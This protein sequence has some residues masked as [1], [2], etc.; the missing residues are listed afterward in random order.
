MDTTAEEEYVRQ[1]LDLFVPDLLAR[2]E[3]EPFLRRLF[4]SEK[5]SWLKVRL[6]CEGLSE[7]EG[8]FQSIETRSASELV[9]VWLDHPTQP[10]YSYVHFYH[11]DFFWTNSAIYN[12][13]VLDSE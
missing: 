10:G 13:K 2:R 5:G 9:V 8:H 11:P 6:L 7:V 4:S 1:R 12:C 3:N